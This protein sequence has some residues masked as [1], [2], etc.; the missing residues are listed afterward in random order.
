MATIGTDLELA[1]RLLREDELVAI[2]TET[3]YGLAGNAFSETAVRKIFQV[4]NRP[5]SDPLIVH[6]HSVLEVEKL[7]VEVPG[8]ARQLFETFS[9]GPLT[10]LLPKSSRVPDLVTNGSPWVA[11]RIPDHPITL[12]LL[13]QL[14]FPLA[15]PS[16]NL[17]GALSPT[18]PDH[19]NQSLGDKIPYILDGGQCRVGLESTLVQ[20]INS[21]TLRVLRQGGLAEESLLAFAQLVADEKSATPVVPGSMLSHYAPKKPIHILNP[22]FSL[23]DFSF[24]KAGFLGFSEA[25]DRFPAENQKLLSPS[26]NLNEAAR[27]L[28]ASLHQLD[29]RNDLEVLFAVLLPNEGIGKAINDRLGRAAAKRPI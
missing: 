6:T 29:S 24:H 8:L 15:A 12:Q 22:G 25:D 28:F 10:I 13:K 1:A 3:V 16:A 17:F 21:D 2:P 9:P 4:K 11:V 5:L 18:L 19:V 23:D 14:D 26:G 27:N 20:I 7:A